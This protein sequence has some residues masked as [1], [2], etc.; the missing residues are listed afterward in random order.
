MVCPRKIRPLGATLIRADRRQ[1][2]TKLKGLFTTMQKHL[3][4]VI[5][6]VRLTAIIKTAP[7]YC[8]SVTNQLDDISQSISQAAA[9]L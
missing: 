1:D 5:S 8:V 2:T 6:S 7:I 9:I 4:S 3:N